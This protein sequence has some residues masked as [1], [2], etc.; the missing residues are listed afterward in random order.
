MDLF[1]FISLYIISTVIG[2]KTI[3][4]GV[5]EIKEKNKFGGSLVIFITIVAYVLFAVLMYLQ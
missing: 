1:I 5:Y 2:I 4:Y 3:S